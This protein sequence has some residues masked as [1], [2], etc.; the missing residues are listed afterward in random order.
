MSSSKRFPT[1]VII[2]GAGVSGLSTALA[3]AKRHPLTKVTVIDGLVPPVAD[4]YN[5]PLYARLARIAQEEIEKDADLRQ[6][7]YKQ[8]MTFVS[9]GEPTADTDIWKAQLELTK[10][11]ASPEHIVELPTRQAIYQ[12]I[13]GENAEPPP[14]SGLEGGSKWNKAYSN[15]ADAFIDARQGIQVYYDRCV[16]AFS[17]DFR[18]GSAVERIEVEDGRARGVVLENGDVIR[19]DMVVVAAGAWSNKLVY[20]GNRANPFAIEVAWFNVTPEEEARWKHMPITTNYGSGLNIFPPYCGEI[21]V[22]RRSGGYKSQLVARFPDGSF[23]LLLA[24]S[25]WTQWKALWRLDLS[26]NGPLT[27]IQMPL[28]QNRMSCEMLSATACKDRNNDAT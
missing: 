16:K 10:S 28:A 2:I 4:D 20:L 19:A 5:D 14:V 7:L 24:I 18:C 12:R 21:K 3:L 8:G 13:H 9:D 22:L 17:I 15:L 26:T 11:W 1:R 27:G 23:S 25:S 6:P